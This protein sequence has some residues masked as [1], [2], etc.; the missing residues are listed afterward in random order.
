MDHSMPVMDG[1]TATRRLREKGLTIP[2]IGVTGNALEEDIN[3]FI[4]A[5][6]NEVRRSIRTNETS[7]DNKS[8]KLEERVIIE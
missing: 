6:A 8:V 1:A 2:I 5:G 7:R 4:Q 3:T